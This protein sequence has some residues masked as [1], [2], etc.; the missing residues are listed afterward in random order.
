MRFKTEIS[1][2]QS[3][4]IKDFERSNKMKNQTQNLVYRV[5]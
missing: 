4:S 1:I 5:E 3:T 2:V